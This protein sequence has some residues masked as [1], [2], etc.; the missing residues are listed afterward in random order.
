MF[1]YR[2]L[3]DE[4]LHTTI[5]STIQL[6]SQLA[7]NGLVNQDHR[8]LPRLVFDESDFK[9]ILFRT[10]ESEFRIL[11]LILKFMRKI[12]NHTKNIFILRGR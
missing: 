1:L 8:K 9:K 11:E 10:P 2:S 7:F 6:L 3:K 5:T 4:K 12:T